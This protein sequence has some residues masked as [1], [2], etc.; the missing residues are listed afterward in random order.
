MVYLED[1][2]EFQ[3][4]SQSL[5]ASD[6]LKTR[7][8]ITYKHSTHR[9]VL[10]VTNDIV[11]LKYKTKDIANL[12]LVERFTQK[13]ARWCVTEDMEKLDEEDAELA[14]AKEASRAATAKRKRRKVKG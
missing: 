13:F 3:A 11:C 4:A 8:L 1:F 7:Y 2:E 10:K 6:P 14:D 9:V 5:F 12:K